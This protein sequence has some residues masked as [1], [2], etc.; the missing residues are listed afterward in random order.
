LFKTYPSAEFL[1][2][3]LAP[4]IP[5]IASTT[6]TRVGFR[7]LSINVALSAPVDK[8]TGL[9]DVEAGE[10]GKGQLMVRELDLVTIG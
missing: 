6:V 1:R 3:E 5:Q 8:N 7:I 9:S 4:S 2:G 10:P